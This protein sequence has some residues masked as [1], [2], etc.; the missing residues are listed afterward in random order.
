MTHVP[1]LLRINQM[2]WGNNNI[3]CLPQQPTLPDGIVFAHKFKKA[4]L[5]ELPF[6]IDEL[7]FSYEE[8]SQRFKAFDYVPTLEEGLR[9]EVF[10]CMEKPEEELKNMIEC[11]EIREQIRQLTTLHQYNLMRREYNPN[12]PLHK[13]SLH[14]IFSG[15]P[16]TGKTTLAAA[17]VRAMTVLQQK[18]VLLAPTGRAAKVFSLYS[19]Q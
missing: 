2:N 7:P 14:S 11:R 10:P 1:E 13:I 4:K 17:I 19:G 9:A 18:I 12:A 8:D 5:P 6:P 3:D 15:S 16:G